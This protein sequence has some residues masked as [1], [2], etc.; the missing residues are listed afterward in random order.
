MQNNY[1]HDLAAQSL[2]ARLA[3]DPSAIPSFTLTNGLIRYKGR[4]RLGNEKILQQRLVAALHTSLIGGHSGI[5]ITY[6]RLK[7]LFAWKNMKTTVQ[8]FV[9]TC[10]TYLQAK[11]DRSAYPGKLEPLTVS[12]GA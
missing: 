12:S 11:P 10:Q 6:S 5:P 2:M 9:Q 1:S 3:L 8:Q 7:H 4:I